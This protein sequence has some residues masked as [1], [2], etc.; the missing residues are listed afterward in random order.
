MPLTFLKPLNTMLGFLQE[1]FNDAFLRRKH[2]AKVFK[3]YVYLYKQ[4]NVNYLRY[5]DPLV[6]NVTTTP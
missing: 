1:T 6:F 4:H 3:K 2:T 5:N